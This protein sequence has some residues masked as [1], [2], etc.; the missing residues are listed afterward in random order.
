M[1]YSSPVCGIIPE[2]TPEQSRSDETA[3]L[4][5]VREADEW[6]AGHIEGAQHVALSGLM[7]GN[8]PDL[9]KDRDIILYCQ[10][11]MRSEQAAHIL[12]AQ[13]YMNII[14]MAGGYDAWL[15]SA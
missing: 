6:N 9:P 12:K 14:N 3:L 4:V 7:Q 11:G 15:K 1:Q 5:D 10:K 2:I 8:R 13:G